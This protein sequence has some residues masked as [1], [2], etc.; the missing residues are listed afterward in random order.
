MSDDRVRQILSLLAQRKKWDDIED[1]ASCSRSTISRVRT[2][3][4]SLPWAEAK[5]FSNGD[6]QVLRVRRDYLERKALNERLGILLAF[7][8]QR[9]QHRLLQLLTSIADNC[10][11]PPIA[12]FYNANWEYGELKFFTGDC[13]LCGGK[14]IFEE[15]AQA[16]ENGDK[17][18]SEL[19]TR[20]EACTAK[21]IVLRW[22]YEP[23]MELLIEPPEYEEMKDHIVGT[24]VANALS[25]IKELGV[26][27]VMT[28]PMVLAYLEDE[29]G[30]N[31]P[32]L[33]TQ[34]KRFE[35]AKIDNETGKFLCER[36]Y[37]LWRRLIEI[38]NK[39]VLTARRWIS[40]P[41]VMPRTECSLC[42]PYGGL[43]Y[44]KL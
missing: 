11:L 18:K 37:E 40:D 38:N 43:G 6:D 39:L 35:W 31:Y 13:A 12:F 30:R 15:I 32:E 17:A 28:A 19:I 33:Q 3:F 7:D 1:A 24:E 36:S 26:Y 4:S 8:M 2:W 21:T 20:P 5:V 27:Y 22:K 16:V 14:C 34:P 42:A 41:L 10:F 9:H 44:I 23:K 25:D 29:A